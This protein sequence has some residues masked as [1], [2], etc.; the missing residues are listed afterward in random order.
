MMPRQPVGSQLVVFSCQPYQI[1][2]WYELMTDSQKLIAKEGANSGRR[3]FWK[4][5]G[6]V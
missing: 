6:R 5:R 2:D 4:M 1:G 3:M